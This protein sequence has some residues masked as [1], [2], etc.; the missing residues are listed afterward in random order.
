MCECDKGHLEYESSRWCAAVSSVVIFATL[1]QQKLHNVHK[2]LLCFHATEDAF[3]L[4][5]RVFVPK[6]LVFL[7]TQMHA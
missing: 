5:G 3:G 1:F 6:E 4:Q 7:P 2:F